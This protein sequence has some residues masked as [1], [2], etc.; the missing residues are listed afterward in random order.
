MEST[1]FLWSYKGFIVVFS[2]SYQFGE[3]HVSQ[4]SHYSCTLAVLWAGS[5][6]SAK[7]TQH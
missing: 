2:S 6:S 1:V 3:V 5:F 4:H 7:R